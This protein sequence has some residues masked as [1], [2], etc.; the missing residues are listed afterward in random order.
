VRGKDATVSDL[1][2]SVEAMEGVFN[3]EPVT[4]RVFGGDGSG[5]MR[6]DDS[7][8]VPLVHVSYSLSK[9]RVDDFFKAL[10]PGWSVHGL[11]DFST[12]LSTRGRTRVELRRVQVERCPCPG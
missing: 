7:V 6:V 2:F 4:M 11:M 12:T 10:A 1:K 9:F 3:F 5:S 8:A